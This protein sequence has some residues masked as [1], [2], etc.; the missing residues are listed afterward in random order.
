MR[1]SRTYHAR[2]RSGAWAVD[3]FRH[4]FLLVLLVHR[5]VAFGVGGFVLAPRSP[6]REKSLFAAMVKRQTKKPF[7]REAGRAEMGIKKDA[8]IY[9]APSQQE[10][11]SGVPSGT[12]FEYT[13]N[14]GQQLIA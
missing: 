11:D 10:S 12:H 13:T 6:D 2:A 4:H 8:S 7:R 1:M 9:D 14:Y 5:A 3:N